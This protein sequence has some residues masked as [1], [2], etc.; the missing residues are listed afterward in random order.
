[1]NL[2]ERV[3]NRNILVDTNVI[4]LYSQKDFDKRSDYLLE[5]L[6]AS[7]NALFVSFFTGFELLRD[8]YDGE[9]RDKYLK[10]INEVDNV[11]I[12]F[13]VIKNATRLSADY[14]QMLSGTKVDNA[15]LIIGGTAILKLERSKESRTFGNTLLLTAN[16][17]HFPE[18]FWKII[19]CH[20]VFIPKIKS[21]SG[22]Q[23]VSDILFLLEFDIS[24][25][26]KAKKKSEKL[27]KQQRRKKK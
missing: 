19:A 24:Y 25:L 3:K 9:L 23:I 26:Y 12:S 27:N 21:K 2:F 4:I 8:Q 18:L 1:M 6:V 11:P 13:Q 15:D 10:F 22:D 20:P 14:R 5:K 7:R 16:R 17:W